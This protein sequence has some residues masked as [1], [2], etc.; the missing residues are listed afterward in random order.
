M[1]KHLLL[2]DGHSLA[3]R[4]YYALERTQMSTSDKTPVWAVYGFLNALFSLLKKHQPEA[5]AVSFDVGRETFRTRLYP[6]YK[7][8]REA[9]PEAMRTQMAL[10]RQGVDVLGIP[11]YERADFEADDVIGTLA[12]QASAEGYAVQILTGDQDAFQLV[13]EPEGVSVLIP[14]RTPKEEARL[15]ATRDDVFAKYGVF[16]EQV[17]DFKALK[18]DPSDN[19]PGVPGVGDKT[20]CALLA[21]YQTLDGIYAHLEA[22]KGK[23]GERLATYREQAFLSQQLATIDRAV[24]IHADFEQCRLVIPD[25]AALL[26]YFDR[27]EFRAFRQQAPELLRPFL[28]DAAQA[29]MAPLPAPDPMPASPPVAAGQR[30]LF[31][32]TPA[33]TTATPADGPPAIVGLHDDARLRV[34]HD[35]ITNADQLAKWV[36]RLRASGA[37]AIDLETSGLDMF[38]DRIVGMSLACFEG[39]PWPTDTR[40][41]ANPLRLA[42]MPPTLRV[43]GTP[44]P[45]DPAGIR[46]A[47]IPVAHAE[48]GTGRDTPQLGWEAVRTA[49]APLLEDPALVKIAH[50]AKFERNMLASHGIALAGLVYDTMIASYVQRAERRHGLKALAYELF[51]YDMQEIKALIGSGKKEISFREVPVPEAAAYAAC[52]AY[53]TLRLAAYFTR[54]LDA[55]RQA[56]LYELELPLVATLARMER[57]GIR[58]DTAYLAGLSTQMGERLIAMEAGIHT[59]AGLPFNL[60]SPRQVGEVLFERLGLV[61]RHKTKTKVAFSTDA[62]ALEQLADA[63]PVVQKILD[64]RQLY[65]LKSTYVDSLPTMV[66]AATGRIHTSFN[67]TVAATGRLS[68][69]EP[70]LQNIPIRTD[71]GR[72]L[73]AAFVPHH[74]EAGDR[75]LSAD[76]S[77]IELRLLAHY[78]E[79][80]QLIQAFEQGHDVHAA[81]AALV[82][83]VP[84]A[85]VTKDMRYKAKAVNFGVIYGQT[86]H[87]LAQ[88][89]RVPRAE[90][91]DF[92]ERYFA[93]YPRVRA[94]IEAVQDTAR[95]TGRVTTIY[96]R[97][98]DLSDGLKSEVRSIREFSERAAFNTLLQGSAADLMKAAMNGL[99]A[100]LDAEGLRTRMLLQVHDELVLN[101]VASE[102]AAVE[103]LVREALTLGQPLRVPL[104]VDIQTG[105]S[106]LES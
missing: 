94:T 83:G 80:P 68:S 61:P 77:Q 44:P 23:L 89:L 29:A 78:S 57:D 13:S 53:V 72:Q 21:Q 34:D 76:Y 10:I 75:L 85:D 35:I 33:Q 24:P 11:V 55:E 6:A 84:L 9:M 96:G 27:L 70:N 40:Q 2:I 99:M 14:A 20:A 71:E 54:E 31:A 58:L 52:D 25:V 87:G 19:I 95:R 105:P 102:Q 86:A 97:M 7:A 50:N 42:H 32:Q 65:K 60:N 3:F 47:Y 62:K 66:N 12:R 73:R 43:L 91:A 49:L 101:V 45:D 64:Y 5:M 81:T 63:H 88:Q 104:V 46:S 4:V 79:D 67:Q 26:A 82:F 56:L 92:I 98:R 18:G 1:P 93:Q 69:S 90:A 22:H 51:R 38:A 8:H 17:V 41:A 103:A 74:P 15:Y 30:S 16:P 48:W 36:A 39:A 100:R 37:F 28:S 106:W 59:L